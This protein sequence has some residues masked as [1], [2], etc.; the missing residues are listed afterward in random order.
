MKPTRQDIIRR[1]RYSS[2]RANL[3]HCRRCGSAVVAGWEEEPCATLVVLDPYVLTPAEE[4]A[5]L[6]LGIGTCSVYGRPGGW[7]I[8]AKRISGGR[9]LSFGPPRDIALPIHSCN[10][11]PI[12]TTALEFRAKKNTPISNPGPPAF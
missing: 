9:V 8:G 4:A 12:S 7:R 1:A 5:C 2:N 6:V 10:R 3:E 11:R